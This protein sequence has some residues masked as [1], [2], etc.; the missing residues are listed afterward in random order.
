MAEQK[1]DDLATQLKQIATAPVKIIGICGSLRKAS[2]NAGLLRVLKE[3]KLEGIEFEIVPIDKLPVFNQDLENSKD[4]SKDPEPVQELRA[5]IRAADAIFFSSPEYNYGIASPLKNAL[6]W[7]SRG[8]KGSALKGK[9]AT[10]VGA[11]GGLGT[12][13]A[14]YQFRQISVFLS[15][16]L[17]N[18]PEVMVKAFEKQED[19][20]PTVDFATGDLLSE[21]WKQRLIAQI[22]ALRDE[23]RKGK[24]GD[25]AFNSLCPSETK[26]Q[27]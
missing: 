10:I 25:L 20:K 1:Q 7:T 21:K 16:R 18:K 13:R 22:N 26:E 15:L 8:A 27:K 23:T 6:D 9:F 5:K 11:G 14:Q 24:M 3:A 17:V 2:F 12:G 4:E 19:G